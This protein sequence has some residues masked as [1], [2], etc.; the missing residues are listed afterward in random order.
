MTDNV[1]G[2]NSKV[3]LDLDAEESNLPQRPDYFVTRRGKIRNAETGET[4]VGTKR[5]RFTDPNKVDW[6]ILATLNDNSELLGHIVPDPEDKEF[7]RNN[8]IGIELLLVLMKKLEGHFK[9]LP[10][11]GG[12]KQLPI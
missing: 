8:P 7:L 12:G 1:I 9:S 3:D 6:R 10:E 4:E 2:I 11:L 5:L